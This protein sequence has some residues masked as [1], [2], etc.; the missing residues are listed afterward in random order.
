MAKIANRVF[1]KL[2]LRNCLQKKGAQKKGDIGIGFLVYTLP[3][4]Q[5]LSENIQKQKANE[6]EKAKVRQKY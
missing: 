6:N 1:T 2:V 3:Q 5:S 4:N